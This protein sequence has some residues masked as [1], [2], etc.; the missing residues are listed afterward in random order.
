MSRDQEGRQTDLKLR[1]GFNLQRVLDQLFKEGS[2][3]CSYCLNPPLQQKACTVCSDQWSGSACRGK[4]VLCFIKPSHEVSSECLMWS[5]T[6]CFI[7]DLSSELHLAEAAAEACSGYCCYSAHTQSQES[8]EVHQ[9]A[10]W[11]QIPAVT[12]SC[13][14]HRNSCCNKLKGTCRQF[15]M[16]RNKCW[17]LTYL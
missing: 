6:G 17:N 11:Q 1:R 8:E 9:A 12:T 14:S 3:T 16:L 10:N 4:Q 15:F 7:S 2:S 13:R 5:F